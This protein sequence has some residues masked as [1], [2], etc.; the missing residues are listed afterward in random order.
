MKSIYLLI[1][2]A[3]TLIIFSCKKKDGNPA[4]TAPQNFQP[5]SAGSTWTYNSTG[6]NGNS[7]YTL[8]ATGNDSVI[9]GTTYKI[10]LNSGGPNEYYNKSGNDYNRYSYFDALNQ[11]LELLYLKDNYGVGQKWTETKNATINGVNGTAQL[12]CEVVEKNSTYVAGGKTYTAVTHIK[13]NPTFYAGG[14]KFT[15]NKADI[16]Y[17]F[18]NNIGF[19][20]NSTDLSVAIPFSSPYVYTGTVTLVSY[21]IK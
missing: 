14:V 11:A 15:N 7:T 20:Y 1:V 6:T 9:N 18:A 16:H 2:L 17:Y 10:F 8:T 12:E 4:P 19:I 3:G 21:S 13:I 5:T